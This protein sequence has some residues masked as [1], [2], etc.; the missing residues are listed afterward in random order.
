MLTS[1]SLPIDSIIFD[2]ALVSA[3]LACYKISFHSEK[4][5]EALRVS[6]TQVAAPLG[7]ISAHAGKQTVHLMFLRWVSS[8]GG[9]HFFLNLRIFPFFPLRWLKVRVRYR[10]A[11]S[12]MN[13]SVFQNDIVFSLPYTGLRGMLIQWSQMPFFSSPPLS[14]ACMRH[15]CRLLH[16]SDHI[17]EWPRLD[18]DG[19]TMKQHLLYTSCDS[20]DT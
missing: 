6:Y 10:E 5:S 11:H 3:N 4:Y 7:F 20:I 12:E 14:N 17:Q 9:F 15:R 1:P 8:A 16:F 13:A 2:L 19:K 18:L